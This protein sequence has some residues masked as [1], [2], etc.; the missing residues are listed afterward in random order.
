M[1]TQYSRLALSDLEN[2]QDYIAQDSPMNATDFI[3]QLL[4]RCDDIIN[5]PEGYRARPD[6]K[7][8]LRSVAYKSY[9]IFYTFDEIV[10]R[11]ERVL[12][13]SQDYVAFDFG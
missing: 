13:G 1:R 8:G 11:I 3:M 4:D 7:E 12:R 5:A 9:L 2:I 10:I 6:I